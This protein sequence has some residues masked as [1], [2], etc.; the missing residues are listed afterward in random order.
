MNSLERQYTIYKEVAHVIN[1]IAVAYN[2]NTYYEPF[3]NNLAI[4]GH[5]NIARRLCSDASVMIIEMLKAYIDG[6]MSRLNALTSFSLN[7]IL[8]SEVNY[9]MES[10]FTHMLSLLTTIY[11]SEENDNIE[12]KSIEDVINYNKDVHIERLDKLGSLDV[13][14]LKDIRLENLEYDELEI[15][16]NS[17]VLCYI[18][19]EKEN[20]LEERFNFKEFYNWAEKQSENQSKIILILAK[21][22]PSDKFEVLEDFKNVIETLK[23][24]NRNLK[25]YIT[26]NSCL[27]INKAEYDF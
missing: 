10:E 12:F 6:D 2:K 27:G 1:S 4:S 24:D 13:S 22:L 19:Y 3:C 25:L 21:D 26:N 11:N 9:V 15:E 14:T 23:I 17:I 18:P 5:I 20:V 16:D 7:K 8:T